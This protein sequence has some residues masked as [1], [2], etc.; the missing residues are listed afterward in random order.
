[1]ATPRPLPAGEEGLSA[2]FTLLELLI[3][4]TI[5]VLLI[6]IALPIFFRVLPSTTA[7]AAAREITDRLRELRNQAV[8]TRSPTE[9]TLH[10]ATSRYG[11]NGGG[12]TEQLPVGT[13]LAFCCLPLSRTTTDPLI[14]F[15]PDGSSS[16]ADIKL[17][18]RDSATYEIRV[19]WLT[20]RVTLHE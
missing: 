15:F 3:V 17:S 12:G 16:G 8:A 5:I 14:R 4:L 2:G 9:M 11:W 1:V 7:K 18:Y 13:K 19:D 20:G 10:L 6:A